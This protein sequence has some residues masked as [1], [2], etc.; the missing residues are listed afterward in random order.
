MLHMLK[1]I[2]GLDIPANQFNWPSKERTEVSVSDVIQDS[3]LDNW[4]FK[5]YCVDKVGITF[6]TDNYW[7]ALI[8]I[9]FCT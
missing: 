2:S 7:I 4:S 8:L 1:L 5:T 9:D 3:L 6:L